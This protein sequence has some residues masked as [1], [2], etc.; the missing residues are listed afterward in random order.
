M[1]LCVCALSS[2]GCQ[3]AVMKLPVGWSLTRR[4][5]GWVGRQ[6]GGWMERERER[7]E[8]APEIEQS[9]CDKMDWGMRGGT[10]GTG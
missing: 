4:Q 3:V 2:C 10:G 5:R 7:E 6:W 1:C 9:G 8:G